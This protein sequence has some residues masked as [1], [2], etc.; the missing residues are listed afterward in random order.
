MLT[1]SIVLLMIVNAVA[2]S[3]AP[4]V[5]LLA[6]AL[7]TS[8]RVTTRDVSRRSPHSRQPLFAPRGRDRGRSLIGSPAK[9]HFFGSSVRRPAGE[10]ATTMTSPTANLG[11]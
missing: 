4:F 1:S 3:G 7:E 2:A 11:G 6:S 10:S 5:A 9:E 8:H